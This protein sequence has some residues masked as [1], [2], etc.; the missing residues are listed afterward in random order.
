ME[1]ITK[2]CFAKIARTYNLTIFDVVL[3]LPFSIFGNS[4]K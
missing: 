3:W 2:C 1:K 4:W